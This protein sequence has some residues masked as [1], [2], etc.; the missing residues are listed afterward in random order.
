GRGWGPEPAELWIFSDRRVDQLTS[1]VSQADQRFVE[2]F[3]FA[4]A[5]R[6]TETVILLHGHWQQGSPPV[7]V[8]TG[9]PYSAVAR[10]PNCLQPH[11]LCLRPPLRR[12]MLRR[13]FAANPAAVTWL[14]SDMDG[15]VAPNTLLTAAFRSL[16][17]TVEYIVEA[18]PIQIAV[19]TPR[20]VFELLRFTTIAD[21]QGKTQKAGIEFD[22]TEDVEIPAASAPGPLVKV[23]KGQAPVR[24]PDSPHPGKNDKTSPRLAAMSTPKWR[25]R[26]A[27][28][29]RAFLSLTGP[30]NAPA[31]Q[32][33]W[34]EL[35]ELLGAARHPADAAVCWGYA[36]WE[37]ESP[38]PEW[39][40]AW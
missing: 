21:R 5:E 27:E 14:T 15:R 10:F 9:E 6:G 1:F 16:S 11:G 24:P 4:V 28:R 26:L 2:R 39:L 32:A 34:P 36:L 35:A 17:A 30:P 23:V 40:H 13:L 18:A 25:R 37:T 3:S 29:Q 33:L 19:V 22:S 38:P 8:G 31:R 12:D 20:P 7:V